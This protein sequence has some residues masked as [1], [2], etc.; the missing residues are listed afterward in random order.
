MTGRMNRLHSFFVA[1]GFIRAT[2]A[3]VQMCLEWIHNG[4]FPV[5]TSFVMHNSN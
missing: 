3:V 5:A 1:D 4:P 2:E